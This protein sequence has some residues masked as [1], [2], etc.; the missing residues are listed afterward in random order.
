[1][2][3]LA[4]CGPT[5]SSTPSGVRGDPRVGLSL[6]RIEGC[7]TCHAIAGI[8]VGDTGPVLDGE[9]GR[10][11]AAWLTTFLPKHGAQIKAPALDASDRQDLVAYLA[12]LTS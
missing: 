1:M 3:L 7:A 8:T 10:R 11:T 4:G 9:G 12:S 6:F 2:L 5:A